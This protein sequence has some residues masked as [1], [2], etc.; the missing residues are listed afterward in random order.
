VCE[1]STQL[2]GLR[3][4]HTLDVTKSQGRKSPKVE[5]WLHWNKGQMSRVASAPQ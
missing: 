1:I 5:T 3:C 4:A 2:H